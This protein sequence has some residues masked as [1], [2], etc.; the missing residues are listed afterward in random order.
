M[1]LD[2][3]SGYLIASRSVPDMKS[4]SITAVDP[5]S[6]EVVWQR[7]T[8]KRRGGLAEAGRQAAGPS[9]PSSRTRM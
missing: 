9:D 7:P 5:T 3:R 8:G 6:G 4:P 2:P 1:R